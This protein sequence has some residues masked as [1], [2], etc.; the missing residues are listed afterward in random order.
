[1]LAG[2]SLNRALH[3]SSS[4]F[5]V[6][7]WAGSCS[8]A[9]EHGSSCSCRSL[10]LKFCDKQL[11]TRL[12]MKFD[13]IIYCA[14][15]PKVACDLWRTDRVG[16]AWRRTRSRTP[17]ENARTT[18]DLLGPIQTITLH[19]Y[20]LLLKLFI[21]I[22]TTDYWRT[23]RASPRETV[24]ADT[25]YSLPLCSPSLCFLSEYSCHPHHQLSPPLSVLITQYRLRPAD[26]EHDSV[27]RVL[28]FVLL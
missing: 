14:L 6:I 12:T 9:E 16:R 1:M 17:V 18:I 8:A 21:A 3:P 13:S 24:S 19:Y 23:T 27:I 10:G 28:L 11:Y 4:L 7:R 25:D 2:C 26:Q 5:S 22:L 20:L 15:V